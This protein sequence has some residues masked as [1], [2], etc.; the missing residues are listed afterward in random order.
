MRGLSM[1]QL[2]PMWHW[3][4][5]STR[6]SKAMSSEHDV[7]DRLIIRGDVWA[8][9]SR[10]PNKNG[11][12]PYFKVSSKITSQ[13]IEKSLHSNENTIGVYT[14]K[15]TDN[16]VINPTIDID[17]HEGITDVLN[18]V[19]IVY[20]AL[21]AAG[22]YPYI[23]ASGGLLKD[24]AHV[25]IICK[26]TAAATTKR[27]IEQILKKSG[28]RHEVNPK[29]E[30]VKEGGYGNAVKLPW[31]YNNRTK[32]RSQIIN[33]ETFEPFGKDDA[34]KYMLDLPDTVFQET[35]PIDI[36][37]KPKIEAQKAAI[38]TDK[39]SV[40]L[41]EFLKNPKIK[42]CV[43]S[44]YEESW[45]FHG[46]G[47]EGHNF[48][49]AIAGNLVYNGATDEQ[50]HDYFSIQTDYSK[51]AT[52]YQLRSIKEYLASGKKPMGCPKI[53]ADCP[54]LLN[55]MCVTCPNNP[56]EKK[57]KAPSIETLGESEQICTDMRNSKRL[58]AKVGVN[59]R[60]CSNWK[61]WIVF[62]GKQ[63]VRE[64]GGVMLR[65]ARQVVLDL[66]REA[67][68]ITD[69]EKKKEVMDNALRCESTPRLKSMVE[70]CQ[71]EEGMTIDEN[72]FDA[73]PMLFNLQN[74]TLNLT[75]GKLQPH[76]PLDYQMKISPVTFDPNAKCDRWLKFLDE[77][78]SYNDEGENEQDK[79]IHHT[80]K[81]NIIGY[82]KRHSGYILT[83]IVNEEQFLILYGDGGHG[84]SKYVGAIAYVMGDYH[85]KV[86]IATIQE[87]IKSKNGS[88]PT[89]DIVKLK[90]LRFISTSE[91]EKGLKLNESRIKDFTGRDPITGGIT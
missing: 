81:K 41:S 79:K 90:G 31:Q 87:S 47:G 66:E 89:P 29:Q 63:W 28:L 18:D 55:G 48:R 30:T 59:A 9:Q 72:I 13:E 91:P 80:K 82:L 21:K 26:P 37:I 8:K 10:T 88:S 3:S 35:E 23:E 16:T 44:A 19:K 33:P 1:H 68:L 32:A 64:E 25:G 46:K 54:T 40:G 53:M 76:N 73:D 86:D 20:T 67:L 6:G 62:N 7:Y 17:N 11:T 75:T 69:F 71:S 42:L 34:I 78:L 45:V 36:P 49:I 4:D 5:P 61:T 85:D 57:S 38:E 50:V 51:K 43:A 27:A 12:Y 24:G 56:N 58:A 65:Y 39:A 70:L 84:K 60:Y 2:I 14:V 83:G 52:T 74:G 22:M 15:P 77:A